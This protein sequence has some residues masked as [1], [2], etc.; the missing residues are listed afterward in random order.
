MTT[1]PDRAE[2]LR[3]YLFIFFFLKKLYIQIE[4]FVFEQK[5][6]ITELLVHA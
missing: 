1:W 4:G 6:G 3:F 5:K 2:V